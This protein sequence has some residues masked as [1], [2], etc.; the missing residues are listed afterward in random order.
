MEEMLLGRQR[1][2]VLV[3]IFESFVFGKRREEELFTDV[4]A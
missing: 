1:G 2:D 3:S 4:C